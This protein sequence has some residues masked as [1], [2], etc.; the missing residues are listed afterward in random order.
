[1]P[2]A[3]QRGPGMRPEQDK[4]AALMVCEA[5]RRARLLR[6]PRPRGPPL[7]RYGSF[8][9]PARRAAVRSVN[10][11][12]SIPRH[13]RA[14]AS[15]IGDATER[16][17]ALPT[18]LYA[19]RCIGVHRWFQCLAWRAIGDTAQGTGTTGTQWWTEPR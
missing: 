4:V 12:A 2:D 7:F 9:I 13:Y 1:R 10:R 8:R 18:D 3:K 15:G 11:P 14:V 19:A 6:I 16:N 5:H 17:R